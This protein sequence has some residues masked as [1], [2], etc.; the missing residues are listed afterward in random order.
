V[1]FLTELHKFNVKIRSLC[2]I[3]FGYLESRSNRRIF[4]DKEELHADGERVLINLI[5]NDMNIQIED[6]GKKGRAYIGEASMP[7]AEMT[8][9]KAGSGL[10]IIKH[11]EVSDQ[12]RGKGA[13]RQLLDIIVAKARAEGIKILPLCPFAK[14]VFDKDP[15]ISDV[16]KEKVN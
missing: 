6:F 15:S 5:T 13:G 8:Y 11:T 1:H 10:L 4:I 12:L 2:I 16:L 7:M 3:D 14:S 9:T